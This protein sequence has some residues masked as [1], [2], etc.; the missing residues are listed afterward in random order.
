MFFAIVLPTGATL[1][2]W[3]NGRLGRGD[4]RGAFRASLFALGVTLVANLLGRN[5]ASTS[6]EIAM[7]FLS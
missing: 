6:A 7:F 1:L 4:R 3:R 2:A 5:H